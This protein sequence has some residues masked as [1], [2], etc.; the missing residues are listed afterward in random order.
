[1]HW[2][3]KDMQKQCKHKEVP[4]LQM[5]GHMLQL[6]MLFQIESTSDPVQL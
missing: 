1:M 3:E 4:H 2:D 5:L 6:S